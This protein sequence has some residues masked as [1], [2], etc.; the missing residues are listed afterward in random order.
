MLSL[1]ADLSSNEELLVRYRRG[2]YE[3]FDLFYKRH[4]AIVFSFL[5]TR[6]GNRPD[7]EDVFQETF[8]RI[9]KGIL[10]YDPGHGALGWV[11]TIARNATID[12]IR[13]RRSRSKDVGEQEIPV[14]PI[15]EEVL[16]AREG[17]DRLLKNLSNGERQLLV[18]RFLG[19]DS[20]ENIA[21]RSG[22][23]AAS[24]RQKLSRLVKKVRTDAAR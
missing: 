1:A 21:S 14:A 17:L 2:D 24:I 12:Y 10:S 8:I 7:A 6:L 15:A 3:G 23:S 9:H 13:K 18:S 16:L 19:D 11:F 22:V 20:F 5:L 4:H